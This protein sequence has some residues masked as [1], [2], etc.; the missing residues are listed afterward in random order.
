MGHDL[1][2]NPNRI[3]KNVRINV[4]EN[5]KCESLALR[6]ENPKHPKLSMQ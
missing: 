1:L 2:V 4:N 5:L 3:S 6:F